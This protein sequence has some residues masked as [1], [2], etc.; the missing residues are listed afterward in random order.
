MGVSFNEM[1]YIKRGSEP[2]K[3]SKMDR[4]LFDS[5]Q[6]LKE[7]HKDAYNVI[8]DG[9]ALDVLTGFLGD[10]IGHEGDDSYSGCDAFWYCCVTED[11]KVVLNESPN[12]GPRMQKTYDSLEEANEKFI[13]LVSFLENAEYVGRYFRRTKPLKDNI[14]Y[15]EGYNDTLVLFKLGDIMIARCDYSDNDVPIYRYEPISEEYTKDGN[16]EFYGE[17]N[18]EYTDRPELF[19]AIFKQVYS[20]TMGKIL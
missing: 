5:T 10:I 9:G 16:Y 6:D 18:N 4:F 2:F 19:Q 11:D 17:V 1:I 7:N 20:E 14:L 8:N 15:T 12:F 13:G 3:P